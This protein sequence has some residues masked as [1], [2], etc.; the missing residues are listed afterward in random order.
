MFLNQR[1]W[2]PE[3]NV[4]FLCDLISFTQFPVPETRSRINRMSDEKTALANLVGSS[5][6]IGQLADPHYDKKIPSLFYE[7]L[8]TGTAAKLGYRNPGDLRTSYPSF[9]Y[10]FVKPHILNALAYL[11][12]TER[13]RQWVANLNFHVFS[14]MHRAI[15]GPTGVQLIQEIADIYLEKNEVDELFQHMLKK[16][17]E[18]QNWPVGHVY[19]VSKINGEVKIEPTKVWFLSTSLSSISNFKEITSRYNFAVGE[20]LP[21]RVVLSGSPAWIEDVTV[22]VI[23]CHEFPFQTS[24]S[25]PSPLSASPV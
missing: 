7:F 9:F 10:N 21:G 3:V 6:L 4:E 24:I 15:L 19:K 2:N 8:E 1:V 17:C 16:V 22:D 23:L 18:Y 12:V 25:Y 20:G 14:E 5:D 11:N 13:G